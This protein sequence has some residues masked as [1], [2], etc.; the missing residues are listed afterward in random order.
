MKLYTKSGKFRLL[1]KRL[2][3]MNV[4]PKIFSESPPNRARFQLGLKRAKNV[5]MFAPIRVLYVALLCQYSSPLRGSAACNHGTMS[6]K[7]HLMRMLNV[8]DEI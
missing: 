3:K 8:D 1:R 4:A 2:S 7:G 6:S 5:L